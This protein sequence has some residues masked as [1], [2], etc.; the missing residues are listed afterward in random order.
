MWARWLIP[1]GA[2]VAIGI[3]VA[4]TASISDDR[5]AGYRAQVSV[6]ASDDSPRYLLTTEVPEQAGAGQQVAIREVATGRVIQTTRFPAGVTEF[7]D[8]A[9]TGDGHTFFLTASVHDRYWQIFRLHLNGPR[10]GGKGP[11]AIPEAVRYGRVKNPV[12]LA[13]T[14][15]GASV[16]FGVNHMEVSG[17]YGET[18]GEID[19]LNLAT[20]RRQVWS[21][22][23][24]GQLGDLSLSDNGMRLAFNWS[25]GSDGGGD[26]V[27]ILDTTKPG[28]LLQS[29]RLVV[30]STGAF[31]QPDH[32]MISP[33]GATLTIVAAQRDQQKLWSRLIE[34]A[35]ATG[36]QLRVLYQEPNLG[37]FGQG[38]YPFDAICR[39]GRYVLIVDARRT[40]QIDTTTGRTVRLPYPD[41]NPDQVA[42]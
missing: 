1:S 17:K 32:P 42:C 12:G 30:P 13:V 11:A 4:L 21:T 33:D 8:L 9:A 2:A 7:T 27:R 16:A 15:D 10:L 3:V 19:V 35:T 22:K 20:G 26:G 18:P 25:S 38:G 29:A 31:S 34:V 39:S 14:Q 41:A 37:G 6:T 40:L 36:R 24:W 5:P 23:V 28:E